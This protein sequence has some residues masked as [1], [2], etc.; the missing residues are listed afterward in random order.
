MKITEFE[1]HKGMQ[2]N[3]SL[4]MGEIEAQRDMLEHDFSHNSHSPTHP[5]P[6]V[7]WSFLV[8]LVLPFTQ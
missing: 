1:V 2:R 3:L 4:Q 5:C 6:R 7:S 8:L